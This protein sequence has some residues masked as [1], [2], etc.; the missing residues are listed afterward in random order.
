[1]VQR[2]R[3]KIDWSINALLKKKSIFEYWNDRNK[4]IAYSKK[5]D[6]LFFETLERVSQFTQASIPTKSE[7]IRAVLVRDY[8]LFFEITDLNIK[9]LEIWDTRQNPQNFPIE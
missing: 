1:M 3:K 4:S 9:V 8:Y 5:L 6:L 7:N 2:G